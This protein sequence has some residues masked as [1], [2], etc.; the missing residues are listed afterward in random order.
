MIKRVKVDDLRPGMFVHDFGRGWFNHPFISNRILIKNYWMVEKI[1]KYDIDEVLIDTQHGLDVIDKIDFNELKKAFHSD[2]NEKWQDERPVHQHEPLVKEL[3]KAVQIKKETHRLIMNISRDVKLGKKIQIERVEDMADQIFGSI[4]RN[5]D[6][7]FTLIAFRDKDNYTYNHSVNVAVLMVAFCLAVGM[8]DEQARTFGVGALL[9]DIGKA[10][11]SGDIINKAGPLSKQ[12]FAIM[13]QHPRYGYEIL[14]EIE[15][16]SDKIKKIAYEHHEMI[17]GN[18]YPQGLKGK[19]ISYGGRIAAIIDAYDALTSDRSY[20]H[21]EDP[22]TALKKI[23]ERSAQAFDFDIFLQFI[24]AIGIYP[25][26]SLVRLK[27]DFLAIVV[28]SNKHNSLRPVVRMIYDIKKERPIPPRN[29]DLSQ[30]VGELHTIVSNESAE[31]WG[32]HI[33]DFLKV[34]DFAPE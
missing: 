5:K 10:K 8:T 6:A 15:S 13:K 17:D 32:I 34:P 29:L 1:K 2:K 26:G 23:Y 31:E 14:S 21:A 28:E 33:A 7:L 30:G 19:E 4:A 12:E 27:S 20:H 3:Q 16:L 22:T 24:H 9:H 25:I 18:G 11:I